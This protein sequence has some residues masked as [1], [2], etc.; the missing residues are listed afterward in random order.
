[1]DLDSIQ[2]HGTEDK[3]LNI[4]HL[5][6]HGLISK[7]TELKFLNVELIQ[8]NLD[9]NIMLLCETL[10]N[11]KTAKQIN[12]CGYTHLY[13]HQTLKRGGGV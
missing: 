10:L 9:A 8:G 4:M 13:K 5:N 1:M 6:I 3:T 7:Q 2:Q 11:D 12:L